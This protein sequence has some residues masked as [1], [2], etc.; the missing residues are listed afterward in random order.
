MMGTNHFQDILTLLARREDLP[1]EEAEQ[2]FHIIFSG[3]ATPAQIGAFLMGLRQKGETVDEIAGAARQMRAKMKTIAAPDG[4]IDCCGTGGDGSRTLNI[5]TAA[6]FVIAG[7][8]IPVA[9]H[10]NRAIT[11]ASGSSDVLK[12]L[13][14]N[15]EV[16]PEIAERAL[17][18]CGMC[19]LM[20]P[21]YHPSLRHVGHVRLELGLRTI[22]NLLGPLCNPARVDR[23]VIGVYSRAWVEPVAEVLMELGVAKAWVV[24][25]EDNMDELTTTG[26]TLVAEVTGENARIFTITP[27]SLGLQRISIGEI[28]GQDSEYNAKALTSLLG[29]RKDA[30]R[31]IV[32][33]NAAAGLVVAG[34]A[35]SL[36]D[37][38][39][40]AAESLDSGKARQVLAHLSQVMK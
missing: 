9:K 17:T 31:D 18:E 36:E 23:Q 35:A 20:A 30:Y 16:S 33:L 26:E 11:S 27:E 3:A 4:T 25:G 39:A 24:C 13:H 32:L 10:G 15:V 5:S 1:R 29:G 2:A 8:G 12:A 22:F 28:R 7:C 21:L 6:A 19:F 40:K 34:H 37:G 14:I 38:L